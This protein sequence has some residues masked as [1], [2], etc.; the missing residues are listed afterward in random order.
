MI[1]S[2]IESLIP[3]FF[4]IPGMKLGLSNLAVVFALYT[5]G[6][7]EALTI[8]IVRIVA[9]AVLFGN[10]MSL[11]FSVSGAL[12]SLVLMLLFKRTK[13]FSVMGVSIVGGVAH[14]AGQLIAAVFVVKNYKVAFYLPFLIIAGLVTGF[15][16]GIISN[17]VLKRIKVRQEED[18]N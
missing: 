5:Y 6:G 15:I 4:G 12:L 13:A 8:N 16:I 14:N 1:L 17:E 10:V 3:F 11:V 9:V 2:Y 18:R 7:K